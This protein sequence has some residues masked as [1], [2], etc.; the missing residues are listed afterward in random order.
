MHI[1]QFEVKKI[2]YR[3]RETSIATLDTKSGVI[4]KNSNRLASYRYHSNIKIYCPR[5][6]AGYKRTQ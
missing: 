3:K 1:H 6:L 5:I 4:N 2:H